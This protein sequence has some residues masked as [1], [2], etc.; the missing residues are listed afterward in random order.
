VGFQE[1]VM[2]ETRIYVVEDDHDLRNFLIRV[3]EVGARVQSFGR[4][5]DALVALLHAPPDVLLTDLDLP[6]LSGETL[7][8]EAGRIDPPP[9]VI[10]M[11]ADR[12]RLFRAGALAHATLP[13]PFTL[14]DL[15]LALRWSGS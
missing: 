5:D 11:S 2:A 6:G 13:K 12:P 10:L 7:A 14:A 15:E 8:A 1:R 9:L 4:G 3:L